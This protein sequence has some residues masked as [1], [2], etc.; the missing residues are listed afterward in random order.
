MSIFIDTKIKLLEGRE[1]CNTLGLVAVA[2]VKAATRVK[3]ASIFHFEGGS[4][5]SH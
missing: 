5:I 1:L 4:L 2:N 3:H